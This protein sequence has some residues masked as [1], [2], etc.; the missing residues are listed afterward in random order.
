MKNET[1]KI[2]GMSC[3]HCVRAV[4]EALREID[5]VEVQRVEIGTADIAYPETVTHERVVAAL[6]E[7][8][9]EVIEN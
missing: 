7:A 1:L 2:E 3:G 9:Y 6:E 8:G 5:G 4:T